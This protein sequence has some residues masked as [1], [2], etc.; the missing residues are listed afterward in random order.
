MPKKI[1]H[2]TIEHL[3]FLLQNNCFLSF[4][5]DG[6]FKTEEIFDGICEYEQLEDGRKLIFD[7]LTDKNINNSVS[8]RI[9]EYCKLSNF[10]HPKF[11]KLNLLNIEDSIKDYIT[12]YENINEIYIPKLYLEIEDNNK[13]EIIK[14]L[15]NYFPQIN[16]P[17]DGWIISPDNVDFTAKIKPIEKMTIDLKYKSNNFMDNNRNI[18]IVE[19][20]KLSNNIIYRCYYQN[21][22]WVALE[23]RLDKKY[24]NSK[25]VIELIEN[26]INFKLNLDNIKKLDYN[27]YDNKTKIQDIDFFNHLRNFSKKWLKKCQHKKILDVGCG[28]SSNCKM[29][30][31]IDP[32][33]LV[34]L[35]IDPICIFKA[36]ILSNN[37]NYLWFNFNKNWTIMDQI[38]YF[39]NIWKDT[40]QFKF[41]K[42]I[43]QY[44]YIVFNFSIHYTL[45]YE[46]LIINI[47]KFIKKGSILK[48]NWINYT[49]NNFV[50]TKSKT[51]VKL[52][53]P[54][55]EDIHI[56]LLFNYNQFKIILEKYN[57]QFINQE[58]LVDLFPKYE[59]WQNNIYYDT[60][61]YNSLDTT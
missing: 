39:D 31:S 24:A 32:E 11:N 55:K 6:V 2:L 28:K 8:K 21:N 36:S 25:N 58:Q 56:E 52:K 60:W 15:N 49:D 50:I 7:Y 33:Y 16:Y 30:N 14:K 12:F 10:N 1:Y 19:G 9:I 40:Q 54:W 26:Q 3:Y 44:D 42:F 41:Y 38:N 29:W 20:K 57:W 17:T 4:K 5:A 46:N 59:N 43:K 37:N 34:G 13:L 47:N 27:Y 22:K 53:L 61:I 51:E 35:D 18:Y 45:N 48:F 23:K